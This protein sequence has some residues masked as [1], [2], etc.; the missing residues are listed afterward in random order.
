MKQER[1]MLAGGCFW[2]MQ[3]LIRDGELI[4]TEQGAGY[5]FAANAETVR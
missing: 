4:R 3:D 2:E 5:V 1:S